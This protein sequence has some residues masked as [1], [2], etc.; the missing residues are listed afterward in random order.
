MKKI[1]ILAVTVVLLITA[2]AVVGPVG[3]SPPAAVFEAD[4]VPTP[5]ATDSLSSGKVE[6]KQDGSLEIK[7]VGAA[8]NRTYDVWLGHTVTNNLN[9]LQWTWIGTITTDGTGDGKLETSI[10]SPVTA[11]VFTIQ[12][13]IYKINQFA[14]GF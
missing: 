2:F 13:P 9:P 8:A 3:A 1:I 11:P 5:W 6:V 4:L 12:Y 7:I 10:T 14:T